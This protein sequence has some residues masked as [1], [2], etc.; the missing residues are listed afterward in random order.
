MQSAPPPDTSSR[1]ARTVCKVCG[2]TVD[3]A[4]LREHLRSEHQTDSTKVEALYLN[5]RI[6]ARRT[7]RSRT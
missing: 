3:I 7:Q 5:A 6:E 2:R 1:R 4:R